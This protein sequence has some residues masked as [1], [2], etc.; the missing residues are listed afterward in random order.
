MA[1]CLWNV[2]LPVQLSPSETVRSISGVYISLNKPAFTMLLLAL[3]FFLLEAKDPRLA[4][5]PRDSLETWDMTLLLCPIL[6]YNK[7]KL[8]PNSCLR[9]KIYRGL[10]WTLAQCIC[11]CLSVPRATVHV[12]SCRIQSIKLKCILICK[13]KGSDWLI[14][15][16]LWVCQ[17]NLLSSTFSYLQN[18]TIISALT[19][20]CDD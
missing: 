17:L 20:R 19:T 12:Q 6:S 15:F 14:G 18:R 1:L 7:S 3:E 5:H 16:S 11:C 4:A 8:W 9:E 10:S 13:M 2:Y